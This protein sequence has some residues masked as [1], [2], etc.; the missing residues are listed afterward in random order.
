MI[1]NN[2]TFNMINNVV[3]KKFNCMWPDMAT[4]SIVVD[5]PTYVLF[6][7]L[8]VRVNSTI[9]KRHIVLSYSTC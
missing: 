7:P 1:L 9:L 6:R 8:E 5:A 3:N 2:Y 4:P